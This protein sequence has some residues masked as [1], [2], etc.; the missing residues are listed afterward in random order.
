MFPDRCDGSVMPKLFSS[1]SI[2]LQLLHQGFHTHSRVLEE[3]SINI[4]HN[5]VRER[6][7]NNTEKHKH[8]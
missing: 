4:S 1:Y 8:K 6:R 5:L 7:E 2:F 3:I